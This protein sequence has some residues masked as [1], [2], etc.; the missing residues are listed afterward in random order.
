MKIEKAMLY[1]LAVRIGGM[2]TEQIEE[3]GPYDRFYESFTEAY[4]YMESKVTGHS[5]HCYIDGIWNQED[6][7]KW[8]SIIQIPIE[9]E[10]SSGIHFLSGKNASFFG[11]QITVAERT[12]CGIICFYL[13]R[14]QA[15]S[16]ASTQS[17]PSICVTFNIFS[18][19][20]Y[21]SK[22]PVNASYRSV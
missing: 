3:M 22:L 4:A 16:D 5:R 17:F 19:L 1:C 12:C 11:Q 6:P 14:F 18:S 13:R 15:K 2:W 10:S 7:E 21:K 9:A 20:I 8:L